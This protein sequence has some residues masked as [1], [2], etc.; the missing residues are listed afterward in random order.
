MSRHWLFRENDSGEIRLLQKFNKTTRNF[1]IVAL[2]IKQ[3]AATVSDQH[4][5]SS[6]RLVGKFSL[7]AEAGIA[8]NFPQINRPFDRGEAMVGDDKHVCCFAHS[9]SI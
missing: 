7:R 1:G 3:N 5:I 2:N 4:D 8:E 9:L 6:F